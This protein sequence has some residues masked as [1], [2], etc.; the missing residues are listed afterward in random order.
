[1]IGPLAVKGDD[2]VARKSDCDA[3]LQLE[4]NNEHKK[5]KRIVPPCSL[6]L[7]V[8]LS[9]TTS[10]LCSLLPKHTLCL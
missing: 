6:F 2:P 5:A 9:S 3:R 8:H 1:M 10:T 4:A 7:F